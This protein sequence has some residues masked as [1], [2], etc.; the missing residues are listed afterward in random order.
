M[1]VPLMLQKARCAMEETKVLMGDLEARQEASWFEDFGWGAQARKRRRVR[2]YGRC[3]GDCARHVPSVYHAAAALSP[4]ESVPLAAHLALLRRACAA[5]RKAVEASA[6]AVLQDLD[7]EAFPDL[8]AVWESLPADFEELRSQLTPGARAFLFTVYGVLEDTRGALTRL[9]EA[10]ALRASPR[11][12]A[13]AP[14]GRRVLR[15]ARTVRTHFGIHLTDRSATHP[16]FVLRNTLSI[17][18]AFWIGWVGIWNLLAAYSSY[19]AST[20]CVI[21]YT[22]T[23]ASAPITVKRVAGVVIGKVV[24]EALQLCFA[25]KLWWKALLFAASMWAVVAGMFFLYLHARPDMAKVACLTAAFAASGMIPANFRFRDYGT[26]NYS[27]L[28]PALMSTIVCTVLGVG[29]LTIIDLLLASKATNQASS[30]I[31]QYD[32]IQLNII[33]CVGI[34]L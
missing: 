3:L 13:P 8:A 2:S 7:A 28:T 27:A 22:Y 32:M 11:S 26:T 17:C 30:T 10:E 16:R 25:V 23:G 12:E 5:L 9:Q 15:F 29:I 33:L 18:I 19:A 21:V 24:G 1:T 20:I 34:V 31:L 14:F 6:D 4:E